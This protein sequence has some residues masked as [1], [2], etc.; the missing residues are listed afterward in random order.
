MVV[1]V[2]I[3]S[4]QVS[5]KPKNGPV[6]AQTMITPTATPN[7]EE[8]PV[9]SVTWRARR[10][11]AKPTW[12]N[13]RLFLL[14]FVRP[15]SSPPPSAPA[16][17][18]CPSL[19]ASPSRSLD[20][21]GSGDSASYRAG[22]PRCGRAGHSRYPNRDVLQSRAH[23]RVGIHAE[24]IRQC[25]SHTTFAF[26]SVDD[27]HVVRIRHALEAMVFPDHQVLRPERLPCGVAPVWWRVNGFR[28]RQTWAAG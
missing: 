6:S 28:S 3:T 17:S 18:A 9:H 22:R 25:S 26:N 4:C 24:G 7:A 16:R 2:L 23:R 12:G 21:R 8:P 19:G 27:R 15:P 11:S 14:I 20:A 1:P 5:E 10:S 13:L